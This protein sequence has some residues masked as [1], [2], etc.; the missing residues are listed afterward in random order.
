MQPNS[1][2]WLISTLKKSYQQAIRSTYKP[3]VGDTMVAP[4]VIFKQ[5][6]HL[7]ESVLNLSLLIKLT[8][9]D[10]STKHFGNSNITRKKTEPNSNRNFKQYCKFI[11]VAHI[12]Q[13]AIN[14]RSTQITHSNLQP[15]LLETRV[16]RKLDA[17][18]KLTYL[19]KTMIKKEIAH[20]NSSKH[21]W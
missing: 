9:A 12:Q 13:I 2:T 10:N 11:K 14:V 6:Y 15:K 18:E 1:S 3:A 5:L 20:C 16:Y 19:N 7:M 17:T 8:I 21:C 4:S